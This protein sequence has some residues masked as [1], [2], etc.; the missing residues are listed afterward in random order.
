[1]FSFSGLLIKL[2]GEKKLLWR[3]RKSFVCQEGSLNLQILSC[4]T[5]EIQVWLKDK[6]HNTW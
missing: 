2:L 1:M 3:S 4:V 6:S 5:S